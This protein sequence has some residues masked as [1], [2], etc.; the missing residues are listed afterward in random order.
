MRYRRGDNGNVL[1]AT[2]RCNSFCL[3]CSQPPRQIEDDWRIE[4]LCALA[5]LVD[6]DEP[7]I[8]ISGGEP[9]LL[10]EGLPR[11]VERCADSLPHTHV[12]VLS[13]GRLFG[14]GVY[15]QSFRALHPSLT[16]GIPLYGD[17]HR[18]H[19]YVVQSQGAFAQT[20][21]GL[22]ALHA[23]GQRIEIRV[24]LVKP[25]VERLL[26]LARYMYRNLP[27]V[28]HVAF[29]GIEPIG[30]AKANHP[31]LWIDPADMASS[32]ADAVEFLTRR[33]LSVS[34]YNLPLC[35]LPESL[36]Q[37]ARRSISN[38]KQ[39]YLPA[40]ANCGVK[41]QC[42]GFFGWVTPDWTS[43]AIRPIETGIR[44]A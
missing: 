19:D 18:L 44:H 20:I 36:W 35:A 4:Q 22:Y 30:F 21:R 33:G 24:V 5:E 16:W 8:A 11:I 41:D 25:T 9:T 6:K 10:G 2:E 26:D 15:A 13:N 27:F 43:R 17:H 32:L 29:M 23:A 14:E 1:F 37:F 34:I 40:C 38:W 28:E 7:S 39:D 31:A 3:M 42:G 12:H